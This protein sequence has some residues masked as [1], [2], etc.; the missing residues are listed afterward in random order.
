MVSPVQTTTGDKLSLLPV[1]GG[2]LGAALYRSVTR[3]FVSGPKANTALKDTLFAGLRVSLGSISPGAEQWVNSTTEAE[4][5]KL[6]KSKNFQPDTSVL[7][8][9]LKAH[10]LGPK[11]SDKILLYFHGGG[12]VQAAS[13]GHTQWL[14]DLQTEISKT[15]KFSIVLLSYTLAPHAQYPSQ[16]K[17]AAEALQ[18]L[19]DDQKKTPGNVSI[20]N[21]LNSSSLTRR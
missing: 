19:I 6:A 15:S 9:G 10:W 5:L 14:Y 2:A 18:W 13:A 16:L 1:V 4:Y 20:F 7:G 3:P 8:S 21:I 12:Y 17:E 11:T